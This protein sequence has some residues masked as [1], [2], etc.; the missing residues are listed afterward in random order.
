LTAV[1]RG[2]PGPRWAGAAAVGL[3]LVFLAQTWS[4]SLGESLTW[5]EPGYIAAGY[6]NWVWGDYRLNADHP[7]LMQKLQGLPLLFMDLDAPVPGAARYLESPNPRATYGRDLVFF[8]GNDVERIARWGRAPGMLLG[9]LL[10]LAIYGWGRELFGAGPALLAAALAAFCPNLLAHARLATEDLGCTAL[11]FAAVWS[12]WRAL[13]APGIGRSLLCGAVTGLA[14][15]AKYTAL[16]LGPAYALL[17]GVAWWRCGDRI[18]PAALV[19]HVA[20][21]SAGALAV[22]GL[23]Y[24]AAFRPDLFVAGIFRIYPDTAGDYAYYFWGRVSD[25]PF[26]F[27][28]LASLL[29]K[30]PLP[31][32]AL[33]AVAAAVALAA[34]ARAERLAF[35]LLPPALVLGASCFDVT[36][37]G[38]RRVL[39]AVPF[40]LLFCGHALWARPGR[41]RSAAV[42]LLLAWLGVEATLSFPHHLSYLNGVAGGTAR[43]PWVFDESNVDWGQDLPALAA[44]QREH[45]PD[46][47]PLHLF[48][49]GSADPAAYG[50]RAV[51][52]DVSRVEAPAP[53]TYAIS[54]HYL[55][56]FRKLAA[57]TGADADW[58]TRFEPIGRAGSSIYLYRF[59]AG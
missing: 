28:G 19:R 36:N 23:G 30:T 46:D 44:W 38:V 49:F 10:V 50:V 17:V 48:Y 15:L 14:L 55:V 40:L 33:G 58:L 47:E 39:P 34:R 25:E 18:S 56:Y 54:A 7:P 20:L 52:F 59:P 3:A 35:L 42:A 13:L 26:W 22:V 2:G 21:V 29:L 4:A 37:P 12:F 41:V 31:T 1:Q 51:G 5:D 45:L 24:G 16:L 53:G 57:R 32:L 43:G 8:R 9:A 6:A 27:H 11:M